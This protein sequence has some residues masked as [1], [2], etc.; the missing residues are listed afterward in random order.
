MTDAAFSRSGLTEDGAK[1]TSKLQIPISESLEEKLIGLSVL[2][3]RPRAEVARMLLIKAVEG[4]LA[5][6]RIIGAL[7]GGGEDTKR[8]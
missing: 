3:G 6:L 1:L 7:P 5:Y 2:S 4:E 8:A